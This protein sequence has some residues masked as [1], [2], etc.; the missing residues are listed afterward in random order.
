MP[1]KID[2]SIEQAAE[3]VRFFTE[4]KSVDP[5]EHPEVLLARP[6]NKFQHSHCIKCGTKL[7]PGVPRDTGKGIYYDSSATCG[8]CNSDR[9]ERLACG[10]E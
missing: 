5:L 8:N 10:L 2:R 3:A 9:N 7:E 1:S 6:I 4:R